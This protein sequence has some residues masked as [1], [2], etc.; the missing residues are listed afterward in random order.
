MDNSMEVPQ[1]IRSRTTIQFSNSWVFIQKIENM[2][3]KEYMHPDIYSNITYNIQI[4]ETTQVGIDRWMDIHI[5]VCVF[6]LK[7]IMLSEISQTK[8]SRVYFHLY[9][10]SKKIK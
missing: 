10:E 8:T 3:S 5:Y 1:K 7:G 2:N 6:H 9:M 4:V